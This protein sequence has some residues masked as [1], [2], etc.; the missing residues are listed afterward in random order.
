MILSGDYDDESENEIDSDT[1]NII[2]EDSNEH[3]ESECEN[4]GENFLIDH[5][6]IDKYLL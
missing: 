3:H 5:D 2:E 4:D 1:A 6:F